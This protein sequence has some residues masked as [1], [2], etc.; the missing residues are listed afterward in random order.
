MAVFFAQAKLQA[1]RVPCHE[2]RDPHGELEAGVW[3]PRHG[4]GQGGAVARKSDGFGRPGAPEG[5]EAT[6]SRACSHSSPLSGGRQAGRQRAGQR[7]AP[8]RAEPI[9]PSPCP[10]RILTIPNWHLTEALRNPAPSPS[11]TEGGKA[12]R[13]RSQRPFS[14][15]RKSWQIRASPPH[16]LAMGGALAASGL[17]LTSSDRPGIQAKQSQQN[18]WTGQG[19]QRPP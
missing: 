15:C 7:L 3:Q 12:Q 19:W 17:N 18:G 6:R 1:E 8:S 16:S 10:G 11:S 2:A 13:S 5:W 9:S 14:G 4:R